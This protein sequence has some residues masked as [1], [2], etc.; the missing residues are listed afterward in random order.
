MKKVLTKVIIVLIPSLTLLRRIIE[1]HGY[2]NSFSV[3]TIELLLEICCISL[4]LIA[5]WDQTMLGEVEDVDTSA[6]YRYRALSV[7]IAIL[8]IIF[9]A[10]AYLRGSLG[11]FGVIRVSLLLMIFGVCCVQARYAQGKQDKFGNLWIR[12]V[13]LAVILLTLYLQL[14]GFYQ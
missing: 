8:F 9:S 6:L 5:A 12:L 2:Y 14:I 3:V 4:F 11:N 13:L 7:I 10:L 1:K